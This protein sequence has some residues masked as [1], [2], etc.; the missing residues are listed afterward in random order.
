MKN[1]FSKFMDKLFG[2]PPEPLR[3]RVGDFRDVL[4]AYPF[5]IND[6]DFRNEQVY[7]LYKTKRIL[8]IISLIY[9]GMCFLI[10]YLHRFH[11]L[12]PEISSVAGRHDPTMIAIFLPLSEY[13]GAFLTL[14]II[15]FFLWFAVHIDFRN[16]NLWKI[17]YPDPRLKRIGVPFSL[18]TRIWS[19]SILLPLFLFFSMTCMTG[20]MYVFGY[21]I[22]LA[23]MLVIAFPLYV[24]TAL[25]QAW[26]VHGFFATYISL[27]YLLYQKI[28]PTQPLGEKNDRT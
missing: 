27:S 19:S 17:A 6:E 4:A 13:A 26:A 7:V 9:C 3:R 21:W 12:W 10:S 24:I 8:D 23:D 15:P 28:N 14:T 25:V 11:G 2:M 22:K 16:T 20:L 18:K 5:L 1:T